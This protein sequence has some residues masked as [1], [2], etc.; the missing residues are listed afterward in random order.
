[1]APQLAR[2]PDLQR[3]GAGSDIYL[4]YEG[5]GGR[6]A[7]DAMFHLGDRHETT[8]PMAR[9]GL[10]FGLGSGDVDVGIPQEITVEDDTTTFDLEVGF[11]YAFAA[12]SLWVSFVHQDIAFDFLDDSSG[13]DGLLVGLELRF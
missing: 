9:I 3:V 7:F 10:A 12:A 1:M 6:V 5:V 8:G 2:W 4:E 13:F 11:G